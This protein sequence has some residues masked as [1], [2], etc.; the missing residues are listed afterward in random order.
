MANE[1]D[2][3]IVLQQ[4]DIHIAQLKIEQKEFPEAIA[5]LKQTIGAAQ[6][7]VD[8]LNSRLET[9]RVEKKTIEE[10]IT[11]AASQLENSQAR[12]NEIKT[13]REYDAVHKQIENFK[14]SMTAG[15]TRLAAIAGDT[16]LLQAAAE[17]A[18]AELDAVKQT[19]APRL[20]ELK[21]KMGTLDSSIARLADERTAAAAAV[22]KNLLR[23]YDY[24]SKHRKNGQV[25]S[26]IDA[27]NLICSACH[28]ILEPQLVSEVR[29]MNKMVTCQNCGSIFIWKQSDESNT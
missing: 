16:E 17:K 13:N 26:F 21:E 6:K 29:K 3:L 9:L 5:A 25:L 7:A 10:K 19:S 23:S 24:I 20:A 8:S 11:D 27:S 22:S 18:T 2:S 1:W 15:E 12:L 4:V 14:S 28:K